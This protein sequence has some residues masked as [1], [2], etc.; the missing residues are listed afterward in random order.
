MLINSGLLTIIHSKEQDNDIS[1]ESLSYFFN[2]IYHYIIGKN[3]FSKRDSHVLKWD[4]ENKH[5]LLNT[6]NYKQYE[7]ED[8]FFDYK[9]PFII[10]ITTF[11]EKKTFLGYRLSFY[12]E[13]DNENNELIKIYNSNKPNVDKDYP[14]NYIWTLNDVPAVSLYKM[15]YGETTTNF[16]VV[17]NSFILTELDI[18][19]LLF[20]IFFT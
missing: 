8:Y 2:T 9:S 4:N 5:I 12:N 6:F 14:N 17:Y 13:V 7:N 11:G 15:K 20:N 16:K 3:T 19:I 10:G 1:N 18:T